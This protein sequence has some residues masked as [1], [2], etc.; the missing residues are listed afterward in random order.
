MRWIVDE[1]GD[2]GISFWNILNLI[3]YKDSVLVVL[4]KK[5]PNADKWQGWKAPMGTTAIHSLA[6]SLKKGN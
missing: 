2:I 3:K 6:H 4:F 5:Y 1:E